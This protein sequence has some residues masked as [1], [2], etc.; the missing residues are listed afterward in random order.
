MYRIV[1]PHNQLSGV[2]LED[3]EEHDTTPK[4]PPITV[5]LDGRVSPLDVG[6]EHVPE[7]DKY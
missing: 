2:Q 4:P 7:R 6:A 3:D 5:L 1:L